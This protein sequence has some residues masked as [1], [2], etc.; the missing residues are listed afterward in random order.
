MKEKQ[1][2][3]LIKTF[4][5]GKRVRSPYKD[6]VK[7]KT[8]NNG[9]GVLK[10]L[11]IFGIILFQLLIFV[12]F[13]ATFMLSYKWT[14]LGTFI[15]SLITCIYVLSSNKNSHSKAVWIIFLLI[16]F[17]FAYLFY[18]ISDERVLMLGSGKRY[19]RIFN[20]TR[21]FIHQNDVKLSNKKVKNDCEYLFNAGGFN[22]YTNTISKYFSSGGAFFDDVLERLKQAKE[23]I[24]I[25]FFI[26]SDGV[27][28]NRTLNILGEKVKEGVRVRII[29]DDMGSHKTLSR[30]T[31]KRI[32][33]MGIELCPFNKILPF[34]SVML[35]YRD[36]RKIIIVDG[37]TA[38][39]GG[40]NLADEY[41][42]EKRMH[43]YWKDNAIRLDGCAVDG[44]TLI[45][46]RQWEFLNKKKEDYSQYLNK[47]EKF[48]NNS[49]Y[50]PYADGLDYSAS[51]CKSTY[52]NMIAGADE[53][54]YMMTPYFIVDDTFANILITKA[55]SGVDVRIIIPE[56]PDKAFVYGVTRNNVEKLIDYGVKVYCMKASF[57]HSKLLLTE[58][59][60]VVGSINMD[61]RSFYQQFE[62]AVYLDDY[63]VRKT[64]EA[65]FNQTFSDS[66]LITEKN[67]LR[68]HVFYRMFAGVMQIFA[69]FM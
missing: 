46:L 43:G 40:T 8:E 17:P 37:K 39:T 52:E 66:L 27:L 9:L 59:S 55:M 33:N 1:Q 30:R 51:I 26:I 21:D 22:A 57:V 13:H 62:C 54:I 28:L 50:V 48:D 35:N 63:E 58:N 67:K 2:P 18:I 60:V 12:L 25:E 65:D 24:F 31:K 68:N 10:A 56:V 3:P 7:I 32:R 16:F 49:I 44:F 47:A 15:L 41:V 11:L 36:H 20:E 64:V 61:L 29:Y 45:F 4:H 19:K 23:F 42:N 5:V 14:A 38:Y 53:F 34:F 69:P 6:V